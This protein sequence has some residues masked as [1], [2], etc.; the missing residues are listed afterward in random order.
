MV[1]VTDPTLAMHILYSPHFDKN[2]FVY[3]F[4]DPVISSSTEKHVTDACS[5]IKCLVSISTFF[6]II[7]GGRNR[8]TLL[9]RVA[10]GVVSS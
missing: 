7:G 5:H 3:S 10:K 6:N 4:L 9:S 1:I 2:A 8:K